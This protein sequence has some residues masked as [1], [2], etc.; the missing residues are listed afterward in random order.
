MGGCQNCGPVLVP[1]I[2]R[3]LIFRVPRKG[4]IILTTTHIQGYIELYYRCSNMELQ[5][6]RGHCKGCK[7]GM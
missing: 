5:E 3:R 1:I 6:V 2:I 7:E 4:I